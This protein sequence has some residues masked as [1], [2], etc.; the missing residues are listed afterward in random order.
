[1]FRSI[2]PSIR[3]G[4]V[5]A[6]LVGLLLVNN[7]CATLAHRSSYDYEGKHTV[8]SCTGED[9]VCPWLVGDALLLIPGAV[10]GVIAFCV[11]F[12]TGAWHHHPGQVESAVTTAEYSQ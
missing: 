3:Q 2:S 5:V 7:G 9:G 1:M 8:A 11:D 6:S 12:G 4:A 10:P